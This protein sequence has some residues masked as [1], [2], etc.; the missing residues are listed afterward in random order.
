[1]KQN[2]LTRLDKYSVPFSQ[3]EV[4]EPAREVRGLPWRSLWRGSHS[5][6]RDCRWEHEPASGLM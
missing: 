2:F 4:P 1:M 5:H 3:N 6:G